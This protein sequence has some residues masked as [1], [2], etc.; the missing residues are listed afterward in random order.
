MPN[1]GLTALELELRRPRK[2]P[3]ALGARAFTGWMRPT[4][5]LNNCLCEQYHALASLVRLVLAP[6]ESWGVPQD[7]NE[8]PVLRSCVGTLT[9]LA[10]SCLCHPTDFTPE[11]LYYIGTVLFFK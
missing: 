10:R 9:V 7:E 11:R 5:C 3:A 8:A 2:V 6:A 1:H 4:V